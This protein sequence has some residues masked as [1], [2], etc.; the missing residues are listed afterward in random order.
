LLSLAGLAPALLLAALVLGAPSAPAASAATGAVPPPA[1]A[2]APAAALPAVPAV[3]ALKE[4]TLVA[5][6]VDWEIFPGT[7]VRAST[8]GGTMP[9]PEIRA[10]EGDTI[11]VTPR[12]RKTLTR[13]PV[14]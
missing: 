1:A 3:P 7:V 13:I 5:R 12:G 10:V 2:A 4:F 11:R 8:Y 6:E 9:G 14:G